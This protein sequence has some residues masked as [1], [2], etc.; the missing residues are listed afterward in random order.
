MIAATV[1]EKILRP[2]GVQ[3]P[4]HRRRMD[5]FRKSFSFNISKARGRIG[6]SP[7]VGFRE[8]IAETAKWYFDKGLLKGSEDSEG[9]GENRLIEERKVPLCAKME[10][11]DSFWE[12]PKDIEKGYST[13]YK[14]YENNYLQYIPKNKSIKILIISCGTGYF[15][16]L[17]KENG[18]KDVVGIDSDEI[19]I[20]HG[21]RKGLNCE[22]EEAFPYLEAHRDTFNMIIAEQEINHLTKEEIFSFLTLCRGSL[23]EGGLLL[24]HSL[25]GANPITGAEALAQ[26]VD[27]FNT[28]TEYSLRQ[29]LTYSGFI[30]NQVFPL[31]LYVFYRNPLNYVALFLDRFN[32]LIFRLN[33]AL[34]G[35]NNRLF[36]KKIAAIARKADK[37]D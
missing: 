28:F 14:F 23:K 13:F 15:L 16:N 26:N 37:G 12:A 22:L 9:E 6:F 19:K 3:P 34:Y 17:L 25:N 5:F 10:P 2:L 8:G 21:K 24:L 20:N 11:F 1:L 31:N 36:T 18:Y 4:L 30:V 35:K 29:V 33:F 27:H 7:R 32:S